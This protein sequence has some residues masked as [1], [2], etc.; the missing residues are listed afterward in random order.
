MAL[1]RP[2]VGYGPGAFSYVLPRYTDR[3]H[4]GLYSLYA[5]EYFLQIFAEYGFLFGVLWFA[6][7]WRCVTRSVSHKSFG[8]M[9]ILVQSLWDYPLSIPSNLWLMS[10]F[11]ASSISDSQE[12]LNMPSRYKLPAFLLV[13]GLGLGMSF[14]VNNLWDGQKM[15]V[16]AAEEAQAGHWE[17]GDHWLELAKEKTPE[18]PEIFIESAQLDFQRGNWLQAAA[19]LEKSARLNPYRPATWTQWQL[20]YR[21]MGRP[22]EAQYILQQSLQYTVP[23]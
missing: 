21:K 1:D 5:H 13:A 16:R 7:L 9:A 6:G 15:A 2:W 19:D 23:K 10:Y 8:T 3:L 22:E 11:A 14:R 12:G 4:V 20:A 18:D 17:E